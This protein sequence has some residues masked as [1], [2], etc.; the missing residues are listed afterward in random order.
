MKKVMLFLVCLF[1]LFLSAQN[2]EGV[3]QYEELVEFKI[4]LPEEMQQYA[5]MIPTEQKTNME[6]SFTASESLYKESA[7][8]VEPA[9]NPF[10]Q[11][12]A[13]VSTVMIGGGGK[14]IVYNNLKDKTKIK[15][16]NVMGKQFLIS[17]GIEVMEWKISGEQKEILGYSCMKAEYKQD[18]S[19]MV[20]WFTPQI[21]VAVGPLDFGGLP[22]VV[23]AVNYNQ[24]ETKFSIKATKVSL[25]KLSKKIEAPKKGKKVSPDEFEEIVEKQM[26]EMEMMYGGGKSSTKG[27]TTIKI[28]TREGN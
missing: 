4:E 21:P 16:E 11:G 20:A 9:A 5:S 6:L 7:E 18:S 1:P 19:Q 10:A 26:K 15:S 23:L 25:E 8:V 14:A 27:G 22:G 13:N 24:G 12:G 2:N 17:S 28:M 3:I